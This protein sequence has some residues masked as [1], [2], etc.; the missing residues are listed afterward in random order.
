MADCDLA[1]AFGITLIALAFRARGFARHLGDVSPWRRIDDPS[2]NAEE[3][4]LEE[5]PSEPC[6][7]APLGA[8]VPSA[9]GAPCARTTAR[10]ATRWTYVSHDQARSRAYRWGEDGLAGICDDEQQLCLALACGTAR[11]RSSR[12]GPSGSRT[13]RAITART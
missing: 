4:R 9:S 10:T 2:M 6:C 5:V 1:I 8:Y 13:P 12:S 11:I 7:L 3:G